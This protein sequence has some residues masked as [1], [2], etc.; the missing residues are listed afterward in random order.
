M[1]KNMRFNKPLDKIFGQK[2]KIKILRYLVNYKKE[3]GVRE[4]AD[5]VNLVPAN[6]SVVLKDLEKENILM[7]NKFGRS[8]VFSLNKNNFLV[9]SLIIPLFEKERKIKKEFVEFISNRIN[10]PY[11][12]IILFGSIAK[13]TERPDSD[14]DIAIIIKN[15]KK[16]QKIEEEILNINA[17]ISKNFGNSISPIIFVKKE[18][19]EKMKNNNKLINNIVKNGEVVAG[20]LISELL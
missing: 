12:T 9:Y 1:Y 15:K 8:L 7:K 10:F 3:M 11:E 19:V 20:K 5:A 2:S 18:F 6:A 4:I 14:I 13:G 17:E 16:V